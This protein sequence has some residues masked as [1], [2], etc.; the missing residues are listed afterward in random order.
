ML[1]RLILA[2]S[3]WMIFVSPAFAQ[4]R[5]GELFLSKKATLRYD[6]RSW[7]LVRSTELLDTPVTFLESRRLKG[8]KVLVETEMRDAA[9]AAE[10]CSKTELFYQRTPAFR[11]EVKRDRQLCHVWLQ[12]DRQITHQALFSP[13]S[14]SSRTKSVHLIHSLTA[15]YPAHQQKDAE[16]AF[17]ALLRGIRWGGAQ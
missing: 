10:L 15:V 8:F 1:R 17:S 16:L 13:G 5:K 3:L 4:A 11:A 12:R 9:E 7:S 6:P 14:V 2:A